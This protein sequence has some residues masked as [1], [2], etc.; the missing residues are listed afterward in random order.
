MSEKMNGPVS[1]PE[2]PLAPPEAAGAAHSFGLSEFLADR[3]VPCPG[4]GYNLR[5]VATDKCPE[6]GAVLELEIKRRRPLAGWGALLLL[7]FG[8]LFLAGGLNTARSVRDLVQTQQQTLVAQKRIAAVRAQLAAQISR[9]QEDA[10]AGDSPL[11]R[12]EDG[13]PRSEMMKQMRKQMQQDVQAMMQRSAQAQLASRP[14]ASTA[15]PS[16]A[17]VWSSSG[18]KTKIG[19]AGFAGLALCGA[20]GLLALLLSRVR[21]WPESRVR[22]LAGAG[23]FMFGLYAAWHVTLFVSEF[24]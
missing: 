7:V 22:V 5:G 6:C 1:Q 23:L 15:V 20:L 17:Q 9:L 19:S 10:S 8:W 12:L 18:W 14:A 21:N 16:L 24:R 13:F 4:C 2:S 11:N 3:D